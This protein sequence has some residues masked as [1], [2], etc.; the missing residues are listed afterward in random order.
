MR[1]GP[2]PAHWTALAISLIL[3]VLVVVWPPHFEF[4]GLTRD[5]IDTPFALLLTLFW[6]MQDRGRRDIQASIKAYWRGQFRPIRST[7]LR[8]IK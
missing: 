7:S 2:T 5:R 8:Q 6:M 1:S 4:A 3:F